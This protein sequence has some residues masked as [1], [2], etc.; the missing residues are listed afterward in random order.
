L[1]DLGNLGQ[2]KTQKQQSLCLTVNQLTLIT[3]LAFFLGFKSKN[4]E[5]F[6]QSVKFESEILTFD[7]HGLIVKDSKVKMSDQS[8]QSIFGFLSASLDDLLQDLFDLCFDSAVPILLNL[9]IFGQKSE[10]FTF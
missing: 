4:L 10:T 7:G 3:P 1:A 5:F 6:L 9:R 8:L 2:T